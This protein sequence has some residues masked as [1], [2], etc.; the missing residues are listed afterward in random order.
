LVFNIAALVLIYIFLTRA[1]L[2]WDIMSNRR[3]SF[4][5]A[6]ELDMIAA[7]P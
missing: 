2:G 4:R 7:P 5:E 3:Q 6:H 1:S